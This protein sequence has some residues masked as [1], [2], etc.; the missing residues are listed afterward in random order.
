MW[1]LEKIQEFIQNGNE[2]NINLD[3][4]AADSLG[5]SEPKKREISKDVSAFANSDGGIIIYGVKEFDEVDKRHLP[6][7]IDPID[8][9]IISKE[10]LEQVINSNISPRIHGAVIHP[11]PIEGGEGNQV[12]YVAE[13]PKGI[14]AYQAKDLRYYRRYN[15]ESIPM[16]D[17]EVKD[18]I[19]RGN[20]TNIELILR[21]QGGSE[22]IKKVIL[23]PEGGSIKIKCDV[24]ALNVGNII[25]EHVQIYIAGGKKE[26]ELIMEPF[27]K[28]GE[29]FEIQYSNKIETKLPDSQV[30]IEGPIRP[31]LPGTL[32]NLGEFDFFG[33]LI[34]DNLKLTIQIST[35]D[36]V[37]KQEYEG[38]QIFSLISD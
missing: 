27:V 14:T 36:G 34:V 5:K 21:P 28:R 15:F 25:A 22:F 10:W 19:N 24:V 32:L 9:T 38:E 37:K 2:E 6:E 35:E 18:V 17:Y 26:A 30:E 33:A 31:V 13:I 11:I 29:K 3:Y 4:K 20:K 16:Y 1:D 23:E 12:I 8:R 7:K